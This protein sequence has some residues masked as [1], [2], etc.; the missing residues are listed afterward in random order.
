MQHEDESSPSLV[1]IKA[2]DI[3]VALILIGIGLV[4][5]TDSLRLGIGWDAD[6]PKSGYFPFYTGLLIV[7]SSIGTILFTWLKRAKKGNASFVNREQ[8]GYVLKVLV[9]S[10]IYVA[11]IGVI[12]IYI[13]S[14]LF[15]GAFMRWLGGFRWHTIIIISVGVPLFLFFM[16]E[17]WFKVPLPKGPLEDMLGY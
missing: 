17:V 14:A 4:V 15:I 2:A 6:G 7:A 11:L 16:F 12:G 3:V 13:S 5:I 9:P 8:L 1:S 10:A